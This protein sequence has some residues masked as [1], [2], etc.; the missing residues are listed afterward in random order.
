VWL[1]AACLAFHAKQKFTPNQ[2]LILFPVEYSEIIPL[3]DKIEE[4]IYRCINEV[5]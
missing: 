2:D 5:G 3:E 4:D 1:P